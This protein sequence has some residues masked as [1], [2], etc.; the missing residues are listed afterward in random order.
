MIFF[1]FIIVI[2]A[3]VRMYFYESTYGYTLLRL[4]VYCTLFTECVL[5]IPTILYILDKNVNL[6]KLY[7]IIITI[8]YIYMNFA[9]FDNIIA[10]KNIDR[11]IETG[12]IDIY[13]LEDETGADAIKQMLRIL[14]IELDEE[15]IKMQTI[16]YLNEVYNNIDR[17]KMDFR[18]FNISK[19]LAKNL[20]AKELQLKNNERI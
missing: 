11:Y 6:P 5:F 16:E 4:L 13:Y 17:E 18:N 7:F 19:F 3:G 8:V 15:G 14:E 12:K 10:R 1:T 9:N 2:S 20:I